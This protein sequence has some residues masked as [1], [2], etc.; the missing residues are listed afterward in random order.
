MKRVVGYLLTVLIAGS[1]EAGAWPRGD[2]N[3]FL[4]FG[5]TTSIAAPPDV[6]QGK[7]LS[8]FL[9]Y[10]LTDDL[11]AG[12]DMSTGDNGRT[13][14]GFVFARHPILQDFTDKP[15]AVTLALGIEDQ[16]NGVSVP[17]LR[18][19]L[20]WGRGLEKGW[21]AIDTFYTTAPNGQH[22]SWKSDV[23][24][25]GRFGDRVK[26]IIQLQTGTSTSGELYT[27]FAPSAVV[28]VF[29]GIDVELGAIQPIAG[30]GDPQIKLGFWLSF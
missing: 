2:G 9:E 3:V 26:G 27:K 16:D 24:L 7:D 20:S 4:S 19:G 30:N 5:R 22:T 12:L 13:A 18:A 21:L 10:G 14:T 1:A 15:V 17:L 11:T 6:L 8:L 23:T 28:T 25:G 29:Q